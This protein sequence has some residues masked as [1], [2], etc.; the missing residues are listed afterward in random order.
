MN[1]VMKHVVDVAFRV[2]A[3]NR[4]R[5]A[6]EAS[7]KS[8]PP[9][10]KVMVDFLRGMVGLPL[11]G[12]IGDALTEE[13]KHRI[14]RATH[15]LDRFAGAGCPIVSID[16]ATANA[17]ASAPPPA[18]ARAEEWPLGVAYGIAVGDSAML[19]RHAMSAANMPEHVKPS[20]EIVNGVVPIEAWFNGVEMIDD[21][22]ALVNLVEGIGAAIVAKPT[23]LTITERH[24]SRA[25]ARKQGLD[26][27]R[28][29]SVEWVI[30]SEI[31]LGAR[32]ERGEEG[33]GATTGRKLKVRTA[34]SP[35]WTHQPYGPRSSRRRLQWIATHWMGPEDAPVSVHAMK[36]TGGKK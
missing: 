22:E 10:P 5:Q 27:D 20:F 1:R 28:I 36:L 14:V 7:G 35:H 2:R 6:A 3:F 8:I 33:D 18:E 32:A 17:F 31:K 12:R 26:P 19:V 34:R 11:E 30:G 29:P 16:E 25:A 13:H 4:E 9:R 23:G 24:P 15:V 21:G